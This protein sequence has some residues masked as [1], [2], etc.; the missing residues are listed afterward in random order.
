MVALGYMFITVIGDY[1]VQIEDNIINIKGSWGIPFIAGAVVFAGNNTA[2]ALNISDTLR[3]YRREDA[4]V[5]H[6]NRILFFTSCA[7]YLFMGLIGLIMTGVT[8]IS[9]PIIN[10]S[11][12]IGNPLLLTLT[13]LFI[14][15]S[16]L[17]T[18]VLS[19]V[20]PPTYILMEVFKISYRKAVVIVG[21]LPVFFMPW[22]LVTA[23][24]AGGLSTFINIA[25]AFS[26]PVISIMLVDYYI[27]RRRKLNL[28]HL[29]NENGPYKGV[30]MA[31]VISTAVGTVIAAL[32]IDVSW[33][34][35]LLPA[36]ISYYLLMKYLPSSQR[37]RDS[38]I[39]GR[40]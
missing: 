6:V 36:G 1:G 13:L 29:Y 4:S 12:S 38:L 22:K 8:G 33:L 20:I 3:N 16:Q 7:V 35:S 28:D 18:N 21:I 11:E 30:N 15:F 17:T 39:E 25:S 31:A 26:G 32:F 37:F 40:G 9:D 5:G 27:I 10:F 19:N 34:V 14:I 2:V 24:S 23:E